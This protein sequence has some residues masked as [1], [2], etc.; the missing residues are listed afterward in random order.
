MADASLS[1]LVGSFRCPHR[2]RRVLASDLRLAREEADRQGREFV[3][4]RHDLE[5][6]DVASGRT[7]AASQTRT[8]TREAK[9]VAKQTKRWNPGDAANAF[10]RVILSD[11]GAMLG[12]LTE[13]EWRTTVDWF[14]GRC[15]YTDEILDK[16]Q[17]DRDHAVPMN[18]THCGLHLFGNVL[19][20]TREANRRKAAKHYRDFIEDGDRLERIEAFI[21]SSGYWERVSVFGDLHGYCEAQYRA[22]NALC[23]VNREYLENLLPVALE[24]DDDAPGE[25]PEQERRASGDDVLPITLDPSPA[26]E[27]REGLMRERRAWVVEHHR[28]GRTVVRRWEAGN[29]SATSNVVGN[30][31]SRARYRQGAWRQLGIQSLSVFIKRP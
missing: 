23:R 5:A 3:P 30:L 12:G 6:E 31:R 29:M 22:V 16:N 2:L 26:K 7:Y 9:L 24:R 14:E 4:R 17:L 19:P 10:V 27:F 8:G 13:T 15:A 1:T 25:P 28:D 18:R 21:R 20:A 11:A